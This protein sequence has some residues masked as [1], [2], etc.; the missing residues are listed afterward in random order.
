MKCEKRAITALAKPRKVRA[1][2]IPK[3]SNVVQVCCILMTVLKS[4][5]LGVIPTSESDTKMNSAKI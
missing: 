3:S 5:N 4:M 1:I 2:F